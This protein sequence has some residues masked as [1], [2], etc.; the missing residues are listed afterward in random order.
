MI[1]LRQGDYPE[2]TF[3]HRLKQ[4]GVETNVAKSGCGL[5]SL[6]MVVEGLTVQKLTLEECIRLFNETGAGCDAGTDMQILGPVVA[7]K[8][9]LEYAETDEAEE[10]TAWLSRGG[11]SIIN[12]GGDREGHIGLFSHWGHYIVAVSCDGDELCILDPSYKPDKFDEEGRQGK[13]RTDGAPF[14]YCSVADVLADTE[15]RS[16]AFYLFRRK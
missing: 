5:C 12:V 16:P 6:C 7:E 1:W 2:L 11:M 13:V 14:L 8:Y 4:G 10:L 9:G 15:N 3:T